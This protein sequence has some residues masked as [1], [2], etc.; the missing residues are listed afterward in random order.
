MRRIRPTR[1]GFAV[2]LIVAVAAGMSTT[3]GSRSLDAM[4]LP[5]VV[6][7]GGAVVQLLLLDA[8]TV[9][10]G[11]P[12]AGDPGTTGTVSLAVDAD[13]SATATVRDRLPPGL[14]GDARGTV[15]VGGEPLTYD[16]T[17][18]ERGVHDLG[19]AVVHARD[20]LGLAR[21]EFVTAGRDSVVVYPRVFDPSPAVAERLRG[22]STPADTAER[23]A[24]D[25]LREYTRSDSLRDVHWK[26]SAKRDD[27]VVQEFVDDGD[28]PT[29]TVA[30]SA[31]AGRADRMAEAAATVGYTLLAEGAGVVLTTPSGRVT[32]APGET[33]RLLA[34]LARVGDGAVPDR[35]ADVIVRAAADGT[36]VR[37]DGASLPFDPERRRSVASGSDDESDGG[38]PVDTDR[39]VEV[40]A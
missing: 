40:S 4:I 11:T 30:A 21:R 27:L 16:V 22:L 39:A 32:L 24:F 13:T 23:G 38:V 19:P 29:V 35:D 5:A 33:G 26:S 15:L 18:R 7:L 2:V 20:V 37:I 10:R 1:R 6:A 25:H 3:F 28:G 36:T 31:E 9:T 12:P 17:Y 8:P 14:D 34:H